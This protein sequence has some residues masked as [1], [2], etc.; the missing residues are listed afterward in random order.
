MTV[1]VRIDEISFQNYR[2]YGTSKVSFS[3]GKK[4]E[5]FV[6]KAR[7]G[8]GKTTFLNAITW[9][10]YEIEELLDPTKTPL[11]LPNSKVLA[12]ANDG[13]IIPVSVS[14][15]IIDNSSYISFK[16]TQ[17]FKVIKIDSSP[18]KVIGDTSSFVVTITKIADSKNSQT[19]ENADAE[20]VVKQY[21]DREIYDFYFF[22]G[23]NLRNYFIKGRSE[24]IKESIYNIAQ[25]TLLNNAINNF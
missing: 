11:P 9:C 25:V 13:E 4:H 20:M 10:L 6:F 17:E 23:E 22:D 18:A 8:T 19:F 3:H 5:L 16:R 7:N 24:R 2:Q 12:K 21:F 1:R 14:L 15:R